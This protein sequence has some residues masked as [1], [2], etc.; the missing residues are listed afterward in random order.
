MK[1]AKL[2]A[3]GLIVAVTILS[4]KK[5]DNNI[6]NVLNNADN[7]FIRLAGISNKSEIEIAKIA[8]LKTADSVVLS[9]AQQMLNDHSNAQSDLKTMGTVV[10]FTVKDTT[11]DAAQATT[12]AQLDS[13]T[14]R[15]FDSTY[16]HSQLLDHQATINFYTDEVTRGNQLNVRA[17][18]NTNLQNIRLHQQRAD[19]IAAAFY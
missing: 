12:I 5:E 15:S 17:Y 13:L 8:V 14:G 11:I 18:A 10:G 4:Y 2:L 9:F 16:I 1:I 7:N 19:S 6:A 3:E